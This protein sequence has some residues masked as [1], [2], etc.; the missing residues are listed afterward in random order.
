[1]AANEFAIRRGSDRGLFILAAAAFPLLILAAY[2][3][4]YYFNS[5]FADVPRVPNL[6]VHIH[7]MVMT[8]W[9]AYFT[10]QIVLIRTKNVKLHMTM[11]MAGIALAILVV[12]TGMTAAVDSHLV[13]R[14]APPGI[15]P[16]G[17]FIIPIFDMATFAAL[18]AGAIYFRKRPAEHKSLMLLTA[19]IFLPAALMRLPVLVPPKFM[20][21]WAYGI[22]DLI[23]LTCLGWHSWKHRKFNKVFALGVLMMI[24]SQPLRIYLAGTKTWLAIAAWVAG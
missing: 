6:I 22:P 7:G 1:M 13:R 18:F 21:L 23:A 11:G 4:S 2:F 20:I 10:T 3:K 14:T 17:F 8:L 12:V 19:V 24:I 15:N 9:V 16:L 5:F